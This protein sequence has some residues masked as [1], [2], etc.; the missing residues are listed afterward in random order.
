LIQVLARRDRKLLKTGGLLEFTDP[1]A[2]E[3]MEAWLER[4]R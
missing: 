2:L 1:E 4:I 3:E